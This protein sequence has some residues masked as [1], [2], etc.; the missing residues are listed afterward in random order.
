MNTPQ[1]P[2]TVDWIARLPKAELHCHLEGSLEPEMMF[3]LAKRNHLSLPYADVAAVKR[4]YAFSNLQSFLDIYYAGAAVL[5]TEQDFF[6]LTW[7]YL[8]RC[9]ADTVVHAEIFFDPQTHLSRGVDMRV[10]MAGISSACARAHDELGITTRL[11]PN[12]LRHLSEADAF[13]T[14]QALLPFAD[15]F[16][17]VGLDSSEM[18]HPPSKF[19][20]VF[21]LARAAG[22]LAVAHAGEEG[23]PDYIWQALDLL[24][25]ARI[26]HGVRCSE[27]E[28]LM[29]RLASEQIA[30]TV[31]PLSNVKLCV[32]DRLE[33]HNLRTLLAGG[34]K[35][36]INSDDP[37]YFGGYINA[38]FI[39]TAAA[40]SLS[41][42]ELAQ[43]ASNAFSASFLPKEQIAQHLRAVADHLQRN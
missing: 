7:A 16:V 38:N 4:A 37:A 5:Q 24:K 40:L 23:P 35:V 11:I 10:V 30:L 31:C 41:R 14:W 26:D 29:A 27:D 32:F 3:E 19:E 21:A 13:E 22:K 39:A 34:L 33:D 2:A 1:V 15:Q 17:A 42:D 8:L 6:D 28:A 18:G 43:I 25:V 9:Q 20:R 12:F 36:T